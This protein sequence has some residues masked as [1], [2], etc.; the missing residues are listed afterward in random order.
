MCAHVARAARSLRPT[1]SPAGCDAAAVGA[2]ASLRRATRHRNVLGGQP[3]GLR[4]GRGRA[5]ALVRRAAP[6]AGKSRWRRTVAPSPD[7]VARYYTPPRRLVLAR[8]SPGLAGSAAVR[9]AARVFCF[10]CARAVGPSAR[11]LLRRPREAPLREPLSRRGARRSIESRAE[12]RPASAD[13]ICKYIK[14]YKS[15]NGIYKYN[16]YIKARTVR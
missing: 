13:G 2:R 3:Q 5:F 8:A 6:P 10:L 14:M 9:P 16:K 12:A 7:P 1:A 15:V 11:L 4:G